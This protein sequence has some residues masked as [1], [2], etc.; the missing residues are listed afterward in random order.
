MRHTVGAL[1]AVGGALVASLALED[2]TAVGIV[3]A[4]RDDDAR[5]LYHVIAMWVAPEARRKG[6]ARRLL[7]AIE[8]WIAAAGGTEVQLFVTDVARA[9]QA[10]YR[11]SGYAPDGT[12]TP[13]RHSPELT[14]TS[15]RK[16]LA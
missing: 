11:S 8:G 10:L 1:V 5:T 7:A 9:A 4:Y 15:L 2:D 14:E 12:A 3:G 6:L 13:S 16:S